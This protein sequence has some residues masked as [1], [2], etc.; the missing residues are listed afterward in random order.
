M[1]PTGGK[2]EKNATVDLKN[3]LDLGEV[4]RLA[5]GIIL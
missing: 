5:E 4:V 1:F 3:K 2:A